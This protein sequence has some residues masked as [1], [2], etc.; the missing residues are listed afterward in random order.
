MSSY[1]LKPV[2][3]EFD[4]LIGFR[5]KSST[6]AAPFSF[7]GYSLDGASDVSPGVAEGYAGSLISSFQD[8]PHKYMNQLPKEESDLNR[9][10]AKPLV[11]VEAQKSGFFGV[12]D[13]KRNS[14]A[15]AS[16]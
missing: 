10:V 8:D 5:N 12:L 14:S 15:F 11:L 4:S 7:S 13:V 9:N 6:F 3:C 2:G 1:Q 16:C